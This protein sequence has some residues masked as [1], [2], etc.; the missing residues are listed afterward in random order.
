MLFPHISGTVNYDREFALGILSVAAPDNPGVRV[1]VCVCVCVSDRYKR[2]HFNE[3]IGIWCKLSLGWGSAGARLRWRGEGVVGGR[4]GGGV[5]QTC[6]IERKLK[7]RP[8]RQHDLLHGIAPPG[9]GRCDAMARW[10]DG[11]IEGNGES[12]LDR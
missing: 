10:R 6:C 11:T 4:G 3:R 9:G 5:T 1:R 7:R 2:S 8:E 12:L